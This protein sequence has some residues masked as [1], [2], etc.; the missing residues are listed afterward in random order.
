MDIAGRAKANSTE[1]L[2]YKKMAKALLK[3]AFECPPLDM[4]REDAQ[5][6]ICGLLRCN[7]VLWISAAKDD[8]KAED[9]EM[10]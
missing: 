1:R 5:W 9:T 3:E 7:N 8:V 10:S 4:A 2:V 6:L